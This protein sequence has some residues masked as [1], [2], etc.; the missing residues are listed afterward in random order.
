MT[1][2][3]GGLLQLPCVKAGSMGAGGLL[4]ET[5]HL[6]GGRQTRVGALHSGILIVCIA[7]IGI[8][9][10]S[11]MNLNLWLMLT[12]SYSTFSTTAKTKEKN[13]EQPTM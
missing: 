5:L 4:M 13:K 1:R 7:N 10:I 11:V 2:L 12:D 3:E 6:E 9:G 8:L